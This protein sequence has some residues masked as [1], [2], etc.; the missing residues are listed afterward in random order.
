[1]NKKTSRILNYI[2]NLESNGDYNRWNN[3]TRVKPNVPV[4]SMSVL[5]VMEWQ[6]RNLKQPK[7]KQFTAVGAGQ[8][9]YKTMRDLVQNGVIDP[10]DKFDKKTQDKANLYLLERRG[11]SSWK[12][13][14]ITDEEFG[15]RLAKEWAS[16][17]VLQDTYRGNQRIPKGRSYYSGVGK[18]AA[19]VRPGNFL[20]L[21]SSNASVRVSS[22]NTIGDPFDPAGSEMRPNAGFWLDEQND[23]YIKTTPDLPPWAKEPI[24]VDTQVPSN[25]PT[26]PAAPDFEPIVEDYGTP[27]RPSTGGNM[28]PPSAG[29]AFMDEWTDAFISRL[30]KHEINAARYEEDPKFNGAVK[31][32][33]DGYTSKKLVNYFHKAKSEKHYEHLKQQ[34][35]LETERNKRRDINN[36]HFAA[37]MGAMTSPDALLT[38]GVPI[39]WGASIAKSGTRNFVR[40][41]R[42]SA[43]L[44]GAAE[45]A[46]ELGRSDFD[47]LSDPTDSLVR[48]G[49]A[50]V[51]SGLLGGGVAAYK[52][53]K[54]NKLVDSI[55]QDIAKARGIGKNTALVDGFE[56]KFQNNDSPTGVKITNSVR[57]ESEI[58]KEFDSLIRIKKNFEQ[59]RSEI[60]DEISNLSTAKAKAQ[61]KKFAARLK[62]INDKI[63]QINDKIIKLGDELEAKKT[64][65]E[66]HVDEGKIHQRFDAGDKPPSIK[67]KNEFVEYEVKRAAELNKAGVV[68][69]PMKGDVQAG[70]KPKKGD[71]E[72]IQQAEEEALK[73]A[74]AYRA[75]NNK[76]LKNA[77]LE[78]LARLM[79]SPYKRGHRNAKSGTTRDLFDTLVADGGFL[80]ESD[81]TGLTNGPSVYSTTKTWDGIVDRVIELEHD[82]FARYLGVSDKKVLGVSAAKTMGKEGKMSIEQFRDA[83]SKSIVIGT[84]HQVNEVNEMAEHIRA[85]Y[86]EYKEAADE[87]GVFVTG[88]TLT[89]Q[90]EIL[91]N[92]L[93]TAKD[94]VERQS[95]QNEIEMTD[96][97]LAMS[98]DYPAED[99][100]TR[101]YKG[102]NIREHRAAFKNLVK[103]WMRQQPYIDTWVLGAD[104]LNALLVHFNKNP[105]ANAG[106]IW[107]LK[108]RLKTAPPTSRWAR[109][110]ASTNPQA[111]D[112]RAEEFIDIIMQEAEPADL[113][114]FR[115]SHRPTF[116]R[117]RQLNIPNSFLLRDGP[118]GNGVADFI[119]TN[120][121][122]NLKM[123]NDR[124]APAIE[125]SRRFARPIDGVNWSQG[126]NEA[127]ENARVAERKS[128]KGSDAQFLNHWAPIERDLNELKLR[129]TNRVFKDPNRWDNR[130]ATV[131]RDWSHVTFMGMS[132][133]PA[134]QEFGTLIMRHGLSKTFNAAF[135][136][137]DS[138]VGQVAK[139]SIAEGKRAGA[140]M[141]IHMGTALS[142]FGETGFDAATTS[143]LEY[144]LKTFANKYFLLNGLAPMTAHLKQLDLSVRVPDLLEKIIHVGEDVA[145]EAELE[146]LA[147]FGISKADAKLMSEQPIDEL[148]GA[149]LANTDTWGDEDLVRKFRAAVRQGNEN[150]ILAATAADKP[151]INDG[152]IYLRKNR[153]MDKY[154]KSLGLEEVG[155][156]Y[157]AQSGLL[158]LPFTFWNYA[159]AATNKILIAGLDEP[160]S[161]KLGGI[162][163]IVGLGYMVAQIKTDPNIWENMSTEQRMTRAID[164]SGVVGV[165]SQYT[166]LLQ[167]TAIGLTGQNPFPFDPRNGYEPSL[168]DAA[169]N[170]AGAGPSVA[171]NAVQG[172]VEGDINKFSWALPMRNHIGLKGLFDSAVDGMERK[173]AGVD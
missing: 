67:N 66:I 13:G 53:V 122:M 11:L 65:T 172:I 96:E 1:M 95:I 155:D 144:H 49:A 48:V 168:T 27:I 129:V 114:V 79:D 84:R 164:Q 5:E 7:G 132:A 107:K 123:Y 83:V 86:R 25:S 131:L 111:I 156:Y 54:A 147:R 170:I 16:L 153:G 68:E 19:R 73:A 124:M 42:S 41:A 81:K 29:Q 120:Y 161:Q 9:I 40:G 80:R 64:N 108:H 146:H 92:R 23:P 78:A 18:N 94:D 46:L 32:V 116:G 154:A 173:Y 109:I 82:I 52:G 128:F 118:N 75:K 169:F 113:K 26:Q 62:P 98:K 21:L 158:S 103:Q 35:Q 162:A 50:T 139:A 74:E 151:A 15:N 112:D 91:N 130:V 90:K 117:H 38:M 44:G 45:T 100:F 93:Q 30:V 39:G 58:V 22:K 150:T 137:L 34:I 141:D 106:K 4:T 160:S 43:A 70:W 105:K 17:P 143:G 51:F 20:N 31:A 8:I 3:K 69:I 60:N 87:M 76:I 163:A 2:Y 57:S 133:L 127:V 134:I 126:F 148:D 136:D 171:R 6:Q 77:R 125:M 157:R 56:V 165:L 36:H 61:K 14:R 101:I 71:Y 140:I 119:E 145:T 138:A 12:E 102:N 159:I 142:G 110:K 59:K 104:E 37:F 121:V 28:L 55:T 115:E 97:M 99:Y 89:K 167:G 166:N 152:V 85:A 10:N 135:H 88:K 33:K 24:V 149:F 47:P 72:K 63:R